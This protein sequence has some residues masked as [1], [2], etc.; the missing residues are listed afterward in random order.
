MTIKQTVLIFILAVTASSYQPNFQP[1]LYL[2]KW[3]EIARSRS[4]NFEKGDNTTAEY[5][6]LAAGKLSVLN[7]EYL[8]NGTK[9]QARG[10]A[11]PVGDNPA[12]FRVV[13][14]NFFSRLFPGDYRVMETDYNDYAIVYSKSKILWVW[15]IEYAWILARSP[16]R[17]QDRINELLAKVQML[18]GVKPESMRITTHDRV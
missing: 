13:F 7:T 15:T 5:G 9:N 18:T 4:I 6:K 2:G 11:I 14:D 12:H 3:F 17:S 16:I 1:D 10:V 8:A